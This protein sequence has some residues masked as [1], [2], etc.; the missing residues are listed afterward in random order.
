MCRT[1]SATTFISMASAARA[2]RDPSRRGIHVA[3][4][5]RCHQ[6]RHPYL[7]TDLP[8]AIRYAKDRVDDAIKVLV[9]AKGVA[10]H[11]VAA[12]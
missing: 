1:S 5:L 10:A 6:N 7:R 8:T 2:K 9:K 3:E 12:E 11:E 4:A